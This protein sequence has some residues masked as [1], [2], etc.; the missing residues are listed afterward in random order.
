MTHCGKRASSCFKSV[1][2]TAHIGYQ[3]V[4]VKVLCKL[5]HDEANHALTRARAEARAL[6]AFEPTQSPPIPQSHQPVQVRVAVLGVPGDISVA[7]QK[8]VLLVSANEL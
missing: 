8:F 1:S 6:D 3:R 5:P 4:F 7:I 2:A